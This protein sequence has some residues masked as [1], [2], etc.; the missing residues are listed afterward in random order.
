MNTRVLEAPPVASKT[1]VVQHVERV[2]AEMERVEVSIA[3]LVDP[4]SLRYVADFRDYELFQSRIP[5]CYAMVPLHREVVIHGAVSQST[6]TGYRAAPAR[7]INYFY[8][9]QNLE[10]HAAR[11]AADPTNWSARLGCP[12]A[13]SPVSRSIPACSTR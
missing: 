1:L 2:R 5:V 13:A 10:A 8:G 4:T 7:P 3:L 6:G 9:A 11:L 12:I